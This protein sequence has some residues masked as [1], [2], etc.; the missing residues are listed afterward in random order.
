MIR[1]TLALVLS[2]CLLSATEASHSV[3]DVMEYGVKADGDTNDAA[4]IQ[5]AID[6]C[7]SAGGGE[8]VLPAGDYLSGTLILKDNITLRLSAGAT[9]WG[10][11]KI[12]DYSPR[13][14]IYARG[15]ENIAVV[16]E[17]TIQGNG[18]AFWTPD[19]KPKERPGTLFELVECKDVR[20]EGIKIRNT[21]GW[22]IHPIACDRVYIRGISMISPMRG[23]NTD[24][25]DPDSCRNVMISDCYIET[26]DD[27]IVLKTTGRLGLPAPP[28]ENIT[29]TNCVLIR[30]DAAL[31]LGTE[32]HGD[33]RHILFSNCV[34]QKTRV[35]VAIYA[36][37]GGL[38]EGVRFSNIAIETFPTHANSVEY[39][40]YID[41]EK[42]HE[43][44]RQS[45]VRDIAFSDITMHT[46]GRILAGGMP[47]QPL[48]SLTF[49]NIFM[50]VAGF[51]PVEKQRKPRGSSRGRPV[52]REIDYSSAPAAMIFANGRGLDLEGIRV[53]WESGEPPQ[54][55]HAIYAA[56]VDD[57]R[58]SEF[59]G[60]P[61]VPR[62]KLAAI[63]L[64]RVRDAFITGS[65]AEVGTQ[66]F[67]GLNRVPERE[68]VLSGN[69]LSSASNPTAEGATYVHLR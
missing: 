36:K 15:A 65:R 38:F 2:A 56:R 14:L 12:E 40:I 63:G 58:I 62:G 66:V 57:L 16:G 45:R 23:P 49:R 51:E 64:D 30:D 4:A 48:E 37:D 10:S 27:S 28:C 24:G 9:L 47:E 53:L 5:K 69:D 20:I 19:F 7:H 29:V 32:S 22:G 3:F 42:R 60:R 59:Q 34:I 21:P 67:V 33:F 54:E 43:D 11:P 35:G 39:A 26:G 46:K 68:I 31:K 8:V 6:A 52:T 55:R 13:H 41:L 44:S 50:R 61:A 17:G 25:I 1:T 18:D